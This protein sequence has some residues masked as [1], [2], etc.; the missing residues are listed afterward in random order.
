[1]YGEY[2]NGGM[3]KMNS[4]NVNFFED[5]FPSIGEIKKDTE[6]CELQ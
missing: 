2:S 3:T 4:H 5:E 6:L 1:M